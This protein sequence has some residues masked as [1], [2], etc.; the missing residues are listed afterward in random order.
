MPF[1]PAQFQHYQ[2]AQAIGKPEGEGEEFDVVI[3]GAG[4]AGLSAAIRLTQLAKERNLGDLKI[5]V[6]EKAAAPGEHTLSGA[7]INPLG[8]KRLFPDL[9]EQEL[10][11]RPVPGER[12]FFMTG[13]Q[14][15]RIPVPPFMKN[16]GNRIVS[17][18]ETVRWLAQKA[19]EA[20]VSIF[21]GFPVGS[22][23]TD[24][25]KVIGVHT[26]D[27]NLGP[28]SER[29]PN[30]EPGMDINAR[31]TILAEGVRGRLARA[32]WEWQKVPSRIPQVYS[33]GV[34]E[35]W[36]VPAAPQHIIHTLGWPLE[37]SMFG[38]TFLYPLTD[39]LVSLGIVVSLDH[40]ATDFDPHFL[41]Q[42]AKTHKLFRGILEDGRRL[43]WGAKAIPEGGYYALPER[44]S[45]DGVVVLGDSAG[46][47]NVAALKG[48]HYAMLSGIL[49]AE[50]IADA[51]AAKD[52]SAAKL[53]A[54]D[55]ALQSSVI[56]RDLYRMRNFRQAFASGLYLG[57]PRAALAY[58][59]GGWAPGEPH[60][61]HPDNQA[62]RKTRSISYPKPDG[63]LVFDKPDSVG[64]TRNKTRGDMP[65]HLTV[66]AGITPEAA[67]F[68]SHIC[69]AGVYE[70]DKDGK[71]L[72]N[73][74]NCVDCM[75]TD[76][77]LAPWSP[78]EGGSGAHYNRL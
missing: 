58:A 49:A 61:H 25:Q 46:L 67:R 52:S 39:T 73:P 8:L 5:A 26:V 68:Y 3:V 48:V 6:L 34:K 64:L 51:L 78:R 66:A 7:V 10:P 65:N 29:R 32:Y 9:S 69:P 42:K 17:L 23:L 33:T 35:L 22:L 56:R 60:G 21:P 37:Q 45:G 43:E 74:S 31:V 27:R 77:V 1:T 44:L 4:P 70:L 24:G 72:V 71:L 54:Y 11:G 20:G 40:P 75:T 50:A 2:L 47:V 14:A 19:E 38:G 53:A 12:V 16:D 62:P 13:S 30:S 57:T 76:V 63:K 15:L 55:R 28:K 36:E 18:G 41:L 59:M